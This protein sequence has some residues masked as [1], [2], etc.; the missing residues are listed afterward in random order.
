MSELILIERKGACCWLRVNRPDQANALSLATMEQLTAALQVAT[1]DAAVR[2]VILTGSGERVFSAGVDVKE[3]SGGDPVA[4]RKKRSDML[5]GLLFTVLDFPKP[6]VAV[7]NGIASGGG[8]MLALV[9]DARIAS[10]T[11]AIA[12]PE[13]N[14]GIPTFSGA[15]LVAHLGGAALAADLVQSGRRMPATEA[16][17]R[18]LL[19]SVAPA[20]ELRDAADKLAESLI[21]KPAAAYAANKEWL[22]R[23]LKT[24]LTEAQAAADR[25]KA[26]H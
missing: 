11:A 6:L 3:Q 9:A 17:A 1:A 8:A 20:S 2:A 26:Q 12:L 21:A 24:A 4:H 15:A 10:D 18:G 22:V 14:I 19:T 23:P 5:Y 25:H 13:I 16:L 7:L